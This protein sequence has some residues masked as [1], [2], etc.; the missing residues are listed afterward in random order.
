MASEVE[1]SLLGLS[2]QPVQSH[3]LSRCSWCQNGFE[4][5]DTQL[6]VTL[7]LIAC[8]LVERNPYIYVLRSQKSSVLIV[9]G[10][11]EETEFV[12]SYRLPDRKASEMYLKLKDKPTEC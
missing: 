9:E 10:Q 6:V 11:C 12:F 2:P 5:E 3:A 1:L 8:F 4:L 7:E